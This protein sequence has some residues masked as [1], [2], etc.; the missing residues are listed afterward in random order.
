MMHPVTHIFSS[1]L[2]IFLAG[3]GSKMTWDWD[4]ST[5]T[6]KGAIGV[7]VGKKKYDVEF[8]ESSCWNINCVDSSDSTFL[9]KNEALQASHALIDQVLG[10]S[11]SAPK[12]FYKNP[13]WLIGC[14]GKSR[15]QIRTTYGTL[16]T[17]EL[18]EQLSIVVSVEGEQAKSLSFNIDKGFVLQRA[19]G[20]PP[21]AYILLENEQ[22][23]RG[24]KKCGI[25]EVFARWEE[26]RGLW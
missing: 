9:T 10:E 26:S 1:V 19:T 15:C 2:F 25:G 22:Q 3:C 17:E 6:L 13:Q 7:S 14:R 8:V 20:K 16:G 12:E 24:C 21:G 18:D 23:L 5:N 11:S 4:E